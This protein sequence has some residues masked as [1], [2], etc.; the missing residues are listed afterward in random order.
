MSK[1]LKLNASRLWAAGVPL[2]VLLGV[3]TAYVLVLGSKL[4]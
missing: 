4:T 3:Y 2:P 1:M